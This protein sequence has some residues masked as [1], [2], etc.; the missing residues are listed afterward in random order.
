MT[1]PMDLTPAAEPAAPELPVAPAPLKGRRRWLATSMVAVMAVAAGAFGVMVLSAGDGADNPGAA[2]DAFFD[3]IDHEDV[4]GVVEALDP[5][6]RQI[7][8]PAVEDTGAQAKRVKVASD[9]L[10]LRK[11]RGVDLQVQGLSYTT[12]PVGDGL[13]AVDLTGGHVDTSA[14]LNKMPYGS[15]IADILHQDDQE[16]KGPVD[17]EAD[18]RINLDG[19]RLVA[20]H[21]DGGW[22]VSALYSLAEQIRRDSSPVPDIPN[23]GHGIAAVGAA[24]PETAVR[25][26]I[27]AATDLNVRRLIELTPPGEMDVLHDYGPILVDAAEKNSDGKPSNVVISNLELQ[28]DDGPDGTKVVSARTYTMTTSDDY[29]TMVWA[30]DGKCSTYSSTYTAKGKREYGSDLMGMPNQK[31]CASDPAQMVLSPMML[32]GP[33]LGL[34]PGGALRVVTEQHDGAWFVSPSRSILEST[35]GQLRDVSLDDAKRTVRFW[36][37]DYWVMEP[38]A[39]WKACGVKKPSLDATSAAGEKAADEC[40]QKLPSD[41][42]AHQGYGFY[43]FDGSSNSGSG[44]G[45]GSSSGFGGTTGGKTDIPSDGDFARCENLIPSTSN[46]PTVAE[47]RAYMDCITAAIAT[48]STTV[49]PS[50]TAVPAS[51]T[52]PASTST[53]PPFT[54]T[55]PSSGTSTSTSTSAPG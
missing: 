20:V 45:S 40:Y 5:Q 48:Q 19:V 2:V 28:V 27:K 21:R 32:A 24:G 3:A 30:Y 29:E 42:S 25:E 12:E 38:D 4:I 7:L 10:D 39:L 35:V 46:Q 1:E 6:E 16:A 36:A 9:D 11:V 34:S 53:V 18:S 33:F 43:G 23:Y 37:G 26:G 17:R 50:S 44:S 49:V 47:E 31:T 8:R 15:T 52:V 13:V 51:T 41:Y 54:S 14:D 55:P 22:H